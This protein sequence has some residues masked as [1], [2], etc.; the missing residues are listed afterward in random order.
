MVQDFVHPPYGSTSSELP[1][2]WGGAG[3]R[4]GTHQ[5]TSVLFFFCGE[6]SALQKTDP[7]GCVS[8]LG[9][10]P[11]KKWNGVFLLVSFSNHPT[12]GP[13]FGDAKHISVLFH[14]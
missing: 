1:D 6:G 14:A 13:V 7:Y 4:K 12:A 9:G 5:T 11:P 8:I 10:T 3:K 2:S